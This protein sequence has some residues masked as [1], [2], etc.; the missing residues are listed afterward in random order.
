MLELIR[1]CRKCASEFPYTR[2]Y[3]RN[4]SRICKRCLSEANKARYWANPD[5]YR[6]DAIAHYYANREI[7]IQRQLDWQ[8][9]NPEKRAKLKKAEYIRNAQKY[10]DRVREWKKKNRDR[11]NHNG[12]LYCQRHP[13]FRRVQ[14]SRRRARVLGSPEHHTQGDIRTQFQKQA[15][16][17]FWCSSAVGDDYHVDH[18]IPLSRGGSD[19]KDNIVIACPK[20]NRLK[21]NKLPEEWLSKR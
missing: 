13:E 18:V 21:S 9:R 16:M 11:V 17:C 14:R 7:C 5:K 1:Q 20:C 12:R 4:R 19:G 15:G 3:F 6:A 8:L 2:E 10:R